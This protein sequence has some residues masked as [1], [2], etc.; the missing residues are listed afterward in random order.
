MDITKLKLDPIRAKAN[1][2]Q[3]GKT[4]ITTKDCKIQ[5]PVDY[6]NASLANVGAETQALGVFPIIYEDSYYTLNN[7]LAQFRMKANALEIVKINGVDY[8]ELHF[9]AGDTLFLS[10]DLVVANKLVYYAYSY[11]IE[12][13]KIPWFLNLFDIANL[14]STAVEHAGVKLGNKT[15]MDIIVMTMARDSKDIYKLYKHIIRDV[16]DIETNPPTMIPF[17]S[18]IFN[19]SD[20]TSKLNGS[21]FTQAVNAALVN[22]SERVEIIEELL[23]T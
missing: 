13:G 3:N 18:V 19:T 15:I 22:K 6:T 11:F 17:D 12:K 8:N 5:F 9:S 7:T 14:F 2:K 1:I 16:K 21:Y 10:S 20:T 23:R 4:I